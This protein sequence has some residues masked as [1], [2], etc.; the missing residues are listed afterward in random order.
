MKG[1]FTVNTRP[2]ILILTSHDTGRHFGCYGLDTVHT[3]AIDALAREGHLFTNAFATAPV[4]APSRGSMM[5]GRYPQSNGL[6]EMP[7]SALIDGALFPWDWAYNDGERHLSHILKDAGYHTALIGFQHE[8]FQSET[9]GF[10]EGH[11]EMIPWSIR[12]PAE[13]VADAAVDF[14][15]ERSGTTGPFYAQIGFFETHRPFSFGG[16]DPDGSRGVYVPSYLVKNE[17]NIEQL[18]QLQGAVRKLDGAVG[19]ILR[20]LKETGLERDTLVVFAADHGIDFPRAK[21]LLYDPGIEI[22][23]IL[24]LPGAPGGRTCDWL[25]SNVDLLPTL[26]DL[27]GLPVPDTV[28]GKSF[29]GA[30]GS[31][32][33]RPSREAI[34]ALFHPLGVRCVRTRRHKLIRN[35]EFRKLLDL[36]VESASNPKTRRE[37]CPVIQLFDLETDPDEFRNLAG[38]PGVTGSAEDLNARLWSWLERVKDPI[39]RGPAP[40]PYYYE[41]IA[42]YR[43]RQV[44]EN[45]TE[46]IEN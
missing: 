39:L 9:L 22:A 38:D 37:K 10:R 17:S 21:K 26:L 41:A 2:N 42:D 29:A 14:L 43:E 40:T 1:P 31:N 12:H 32:T 44:H 27:I 33:A 15:K 34:F 19:T 25:L 18:A 23:L 46:G 4:C 30:F 5:T 7:K 28:E 35:F 20:A 24:R 8:A 6:M 45:G 36:P 16:V 11:A 13:V 3:P